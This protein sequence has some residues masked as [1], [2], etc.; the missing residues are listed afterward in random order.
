M[1][2]LRNAIFFFYFLLRSS[3]S[4]TA[5]VYD[6][7]GTIHI[8]SIRLRSHRYII[9]KIR[10][11]TPTNGMPPRVRPFIQHRRVEVWCVSSIHPY[12]L[13]PHINTEHRTYTH[14]IHVAKCTMQTATHRTFAFSPYFSCYFYWMGWLV[15][16][17]FLLRWPAYFAHI[18]RCV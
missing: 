13:H 12:T 6:Q 2:S 1:L 5:L 18:V 10:W 8:Y 11:I 14:K 3:F 4:V 9:I 17:V 15:G 16:L 7:I